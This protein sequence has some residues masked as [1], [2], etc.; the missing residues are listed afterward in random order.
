MADEVEY[1]SGTE[2]LTDTGYTQVFCGGCGWYTARKIHATD[3]WDMF[4]SHK[5]HCSSLEG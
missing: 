2:S 1:P 5:I 4:D 3:A